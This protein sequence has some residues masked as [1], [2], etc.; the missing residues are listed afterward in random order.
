MTTPDLIERMA[1]AIANWQDDT[2]WNRMGELS[3]ISS[4]MHQD[5]YRT[6]AQAAL[7]AIQEAGYVVVPKPAS[8]EGYTEEDWEKWWE[9]NA[10]SYRESTR[11][12]LQN[13][14][15]ILGP[16]S[17]CVGQADPSA[18]HKDEGK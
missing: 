10:P 2:N 1:R 12:A 3:P 4:E 6:I 18:I 13:W 8:F 11:R 15:K 16:Q 17:K 14:R 7:S 5:H 9:A